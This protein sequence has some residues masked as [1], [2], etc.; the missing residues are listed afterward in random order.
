[1]YQYCINSPKGFIK[2]YI[3]I[4]ASNL[5]VTSV[6]FFD[7]PI[8]INHKNTL[9]EQCISELIDYFSGHLVEFTVP[10]DLQ[11]TDFQKNVWRAL[12][13]IPYGITM[14]YM[15]LA[16]KVGSKNYCRAVGMANSKNPISIIIPCHRII[17]KNGKLVGYAGGIEIKHWLIEHEKKNK[18]K[19]A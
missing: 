2:K 4:T 11:G 16:I 14:S 7:D 5:G 19:V 1:M 3:H 6:L 12:M 18:N 13:T 10:V 17:G 15:E 9:I 8:P